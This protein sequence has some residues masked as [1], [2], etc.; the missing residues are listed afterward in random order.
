[1]FHQV[2]VWGLTL[3]IQHA[4]REPLGLRA[5][6]CVR[7]RMCILSLHNTVSRRPQRSA[8]CRMSHIFRERRF[9]FSKHT[10]EMSENIYRQTTAKATLN[11]TPTHQQRLNRPLV[12]TPFKLFVNPDVP[13]ENICQV[14][15]F[16]I[17]DGGG[18]EAAP[19]LNFFFESNSSFHFWVKVS[20]S[21]AVRRGSAYNLT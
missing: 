7:A 1:M 11:T 8:A 17:F 9:A 13:N 16:F 20:I 5:Y 4:P 2:A 19:L 14:Q 6:R 15:I 10:A 21:K 12:I 3:R 18:E